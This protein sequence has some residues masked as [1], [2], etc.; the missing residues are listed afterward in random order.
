[1][2]EPT[3]KTVRQ[4]GENAEQDITAEKTP[5]PEKQAGADI[6]EAIIDEA[7]DTPPR[8][9]EHTEEQPA[10]KKRAKSRLSSRARMSL[11]LSLMAL[12]TFR[13]A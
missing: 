10:Q 4:G 6:P 9:T 1:M 11:I 5:K 8:E 2:N 3:E 7:V 12:I 13:R